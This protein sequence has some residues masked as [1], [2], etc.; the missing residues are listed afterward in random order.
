MASM[1][2]LS[3]VPS[4]LE[5][6]PLCA[7][8]PFPCRHPVQEG[9]LQEEGCVVSKE[10][11]QRRKW[12]QVVTG[13]GQQWPLA[14]PGLTLP[15]AK[16]SADEGCSPQAVLGAL[17]PRP[18]LPHTLSPGWLMQV[19]PLPLNLAWANYPNNLTSLCLFFCL[20]N[21]ESKS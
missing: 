18:C 20:Q 4:R 12:L 13:R 2:V 5:P 14:S 15:R 19:S 6:L 16:M 3:K 8:A 7:C 9:E 11:Q 10:P 1:R 21:K 17:S